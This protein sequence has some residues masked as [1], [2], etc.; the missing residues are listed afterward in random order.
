[1]R[2]LPEL[3]ILLLF[4]AIT[5]AAA[6]K[7][8]WTTHTGDRAEHGARLLDGRLYVAGAAKLTVLEP[9]TGAI[10]RF[11]LPPDS[12]PLSSG[13]LVTSGGV[14]AGDDAGRIVRWPA[15]GPGVVLGA[16]RRAKAITALRAGADDRI[17]T[18]DRAGC[19]TAMDPLAAKA[20]SH[21]TAGAIGRALLAAEELVFAG[22]ARSRVTAWS[23]A[24]GGYRWAYQCD[25]ALAGAPVVADD[26]VLLTGVD[27]HLYALDRA[28]GAL[29]WRT[30]VGDKIHGGPA[31]GAG[32][33]VVAT[34]TRGLVAID[35]ATGK[36]AWRASLPATKATPS[37]IDGLVV[38]GAADYA[39]HAFDAAT[40]KRRWRVPLAG[41]VL[42]AP[43]P[44]EEGI[45]AVTEDGVAVLLK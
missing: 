14:V 2:R 17:L 5:M 32:L 13:P 21:C 26:V 39:L 43:L 37:I 16:L 29:R 27:G 12:T 28:R 7:V 3:F 1:V 24:K 36:A 18:G 19:V 6:P 23:A 8:A 20:W 42:A 11:L 9:G 38:V 15:V 25:A 34:E 44:S 40:G 30:H 4:P 31:L 33:V 41:A 45:L 22:D 10:Q 35:V